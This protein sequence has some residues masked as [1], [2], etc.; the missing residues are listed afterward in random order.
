MAQVPKRYIPKELS[1]RDRGEQIRQLRK[2]RKEYKRGKYHA[3]KKLDS[4]KSR[5]SP[6]IRK[7][8]TMY[9]IESIA[10]STTLARKTG[11]T[12]RALRHIVRKGKGAYF[13]SGSRP[14][15]TGTS[16]GIARLASAI[17]GG[18]RQVDMHILEK[19]V[20]LKV[21]ALKLA[22]R[23]KRVRKVKN[24]ANRRSKNEGENCRL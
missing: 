21:E 4:F 3:R 9:K 14:N 19:D 13:S 22:R 16:W 10:P 1:R 24:K 18:P 7:A 12:K 15:Q 6:H 2:S 8:K 11:C 20:M 23:T 17:T 5:E